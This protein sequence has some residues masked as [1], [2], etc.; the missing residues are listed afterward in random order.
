MS[1]MPAIA[2]AVVIAMN[3][4]AKVVRAGFSS[5]QSF[6]YRGASKKPA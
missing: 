2:H 6:S 4:P 3:I 5:T 1:H